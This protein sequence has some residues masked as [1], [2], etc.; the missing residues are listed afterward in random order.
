MH[1]GHKL[2][3]QKHMS[4]YKTWL[5]QIIPSMPPL[6]LLTIKKNIFSFLVLKMLFF[7]LNFF[8]FSFLHVDS[9][10]MIDFYAADNDKDGITDV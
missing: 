1:Y 5:V 3:R 2:A 4:S 9:D 7:A 8:I 10:G 6:N